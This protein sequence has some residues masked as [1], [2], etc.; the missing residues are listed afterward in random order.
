VTKPFSLM[1]LMARIGV[2]LRRSSAARPNVLATRDLIVDFRA[3]R[4]SRSGT[5]VGLTE[6]EFQ[7]LEVLAARRGD[8]VARTDLIAR[9]WGR[10]V[11]AEVSTRPVDQHVAAL[12]R[13]L[14]DN[15]EAPTLI[16]TVY[17]FGYR[18]AD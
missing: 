11:G 3:R 13:K 6:R 12:R 1:E 8:A 4:A 15:A 7:V 10:L 18:L 17:G 9:I 16:E 2:L 5:P 14:G